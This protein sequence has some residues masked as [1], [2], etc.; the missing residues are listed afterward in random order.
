MAR[1]ETIEKLRK[2]LLMRREALARS[3]KGDLSLLRELHGETSG[4][5]LDAAADSV[6]DEINSR[7]L[8]VESD[9]LVAIDG[10]LERLN[11]GSYGVCQDCG[12]PIPL[13]RL[14]AVPYVVDCIDCRRA[15]EK[16]SEAKA[17][18]WN[19]SVGYYGYS[20]N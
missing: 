2:T 19:D 8:E 14:Q 7:L 18:G 13:R 1:K 12:K 15:A 16:R 11:D 17:T 9:E 4:D 6:Q 3:I 5:I 20:A 10:A